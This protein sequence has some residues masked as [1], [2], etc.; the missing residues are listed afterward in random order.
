MGKKAKTRRETTARP[1]SAA[2]TMRTAPNWPLLAISVAGMLLAGY[3]AWTA[4]GGESVRGCGIGSG[5]DIVL[6]SDWSKFLGMPTALWGFLTYTVLARTAF[7]KRVDRHWQYA[8]TV[9]L[10]GMLFSAYLTV[11]ALTYLKAACPYCLTSFGLM[12]ASFVLVTWQRPADLRRF[13]W[14]NWLAKT[15][16]V[17]LI[18][19][20]LMH[21]SYTGVI[22]GL[23]TPED[24]VARALA[25]HLT[26]T[27]ARFY[28]ASWCPHCQQ[29]KRIFGSA[30]ARLPY[31][32][33][34]PGG[35]QGSPT[36]KACLDAGVRSYPTWFINGE[37]IEEVVGIQQLKDKSGFKAPPPAATP[38]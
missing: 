33:C 31:I 28:G 6:S 35:R 3:M 29:Q 36:A 37:K 19:I 23:T 8:W 27:G 26:K 1:A 38:K 7:V 13:S 2:G 10:F 12:L 11:V 18:F 16:S 34:S 22:G 30:A 25:E 20:L 17:P 14:P 32:E 4:L 9:S 21:L 15:A 24:P 5:C